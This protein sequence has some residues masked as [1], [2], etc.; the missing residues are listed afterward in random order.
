M[1]A[2]RLRTG[3]EVSPAG[4]V[5]SQT[6]RPPDDARPLAHVVGIEDSKGYYN[7]KHCKIQ[8]FLCFKKLSAQISAQT[9]DPVSFSEWLTD[10]G[11]AFPEDNL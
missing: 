10:L 2:S 1:P 5:G 9:Y 7:K 3:F 8:G 6:C 4:S 11:N